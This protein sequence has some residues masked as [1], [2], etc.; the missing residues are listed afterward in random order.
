MQRRGRGEG[1]DGSLP[2]RGSDWEGPVGDRGGHR[3][4]VRQ[5][6]RG[7]LRLGRPTTWRS[8][9]VALLLSCA[10]GAPRITTCLEWLRGTQGLQQDPGRCSTVPSGLLARREVRQNIPY[11]PRCGKSEADFLHMTWSCPSVLRVWHDVTAQTA[12]WS[13]LP[14]LPTPESCL[15]GVRRR[16]GKEKQRH[17]CADLPFV[18]LKRLIVFQ[19]KSPIAPD[20]HRWS[21]ELLHWARAEAQVLHTLCDSGV[22]VKGADIW[23]SFIEQLEQKDDTRPP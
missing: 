10:A 23:D 6:P 15:L 19:W 14:L 17:R 2:E 5:S 13:G 3:A 11:C 9:G 12:A 7:H 4:V 8:G 20:I 22:V 18:L 16:R 1:K 21:S